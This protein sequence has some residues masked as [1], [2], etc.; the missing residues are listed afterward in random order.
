[1]KTPKH[2]AHPKDLRDPRARK[3]FKKD[4]VKGI[5]AEVEAERAKQSKR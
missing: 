4:L 5:V 1:M 3:A 2:I